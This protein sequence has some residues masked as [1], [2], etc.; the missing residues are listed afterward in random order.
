MTSFCS[1]SVVGIRLRWITLLFES[2]E[3][4]ECLLCAAAAMHV[5]LKW[6]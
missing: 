1:D 6:N 4:R 3:S 2:S 5:G